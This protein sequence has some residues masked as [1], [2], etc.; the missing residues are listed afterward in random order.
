MQ[1]SCLPLVGFLLGEGAEVADAW[2]GTELG[3]EVPDAQA[4]CVAEERA[5]AGLGRK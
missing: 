1:F 3:S 2:T 4:G 5:P